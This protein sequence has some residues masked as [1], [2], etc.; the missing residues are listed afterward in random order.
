MW[1]THQAFNGFTPSDSVWKA[2]SVPQPFFLETEHHVCIVSRRLK[3]AAAEIHLFLT[4]HQHTARGEVTFMEMRKMSGSRT[5]AKPTT[6][7]LTSA[8]MVHCVCSCISLL[9]SKYVILISIRGLNQTC[10]SSIQFTIS[11][12]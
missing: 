3:K 8:E 2:M 5:E 11:I 6:D 1:T 4:D 10:L 7:P 9:L 12:K